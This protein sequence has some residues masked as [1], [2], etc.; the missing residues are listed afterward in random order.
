MSRRPTIYDIARAA[1][2][3]TAT[4]SRVINQSGKVSEET[5]RRVL[6][7]ASELGF[8]PNRLLFHPPG[9]KNTVAVILPKIACAFDALVISGIER[10]VSERE[11][12]HL[13]VYQ[14]HGDIETEQRILRGV[15]DRGAVGAI[16]F[17][18]ATDIAVD[19][20]HLDRRNTAHC[21]VVLVDQAVEGAELDLVHADHLSGAAKA[22]DH[23][24]SLGYRRIGMLAGP[25]GVY[26]SVNRIKGFQVSLD[27]HGLEC[28]D[29]WLRI[30]EYSRESGY[31]LTREILDLP[32]R[33]EA[34]FA[35]NSDIAVGALDA[36]YDA[37][38]SV[39]EDM[40]LIAFD[41]VDAQS[42]LYR[43]FT[44]VSQPARLIGEI[45]FDLVFRR[46]DGIL[47]DSPVE[48][49]V[50]VSLIIGKSCG[51]ALRMGLG[52][53]AATV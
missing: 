21:P 22:V 45:A 24:C 7:A 25:P 28:R 16:L 43:F 12:F 27:A 50:G 33:P 38:L 23:L 31:R 51:A 36:L 39:P 34:L 52:E 44:V 37:G 53:S 32:E 3:S 8:Y 4:V 11:G 40:A 2:V 5:R 48:I 30:G 35:A 20:Y 9:F 42:E 15:M 6:K 26:S 46:T 41:T 14:T 17:S 19:G 49:T 13:A 18:Q 1:S 47:D 10:R 29:E